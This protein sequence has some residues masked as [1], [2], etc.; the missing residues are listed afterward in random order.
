MVQTV[1]SLGFSFDEKG[2]TNTKANNRT[3]TIHASRTSLK[4]SR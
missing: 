2:S 4:E 1:G 3:M